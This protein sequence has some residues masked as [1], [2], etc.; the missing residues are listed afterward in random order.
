[1]G[2]G[3]ETEIVI[4]ALISDQISEMCRVKRPN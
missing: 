2:S 3:W 1:M 4:V